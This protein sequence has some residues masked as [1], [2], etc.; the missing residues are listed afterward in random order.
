LFFVIELLQKNPLH[1]VQYVLAGLAL[2][3]FYTLLLSI[4][5]F[6]MFDAA[7]TIAAAATV[8]LITL[9]AWWHFKKTGIALLFL[10]SLAVLYGFIFVLIRLEDTALLVGSISLFIIL[11]TLMYASRRIKWYGEKAVAPNGSLPVQPE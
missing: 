4:S 7:Y 11:A 10:V 9:Y 8:L 6:L 5:E 1:P 2:L 3:V